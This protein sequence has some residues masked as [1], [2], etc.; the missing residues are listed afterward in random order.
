MH[1]THTHTRHRQ[2]GFTDLIVLHETRGEPDGMI[3]QHLPYGPSFY[4]TLFNVVTRHEIPNVGHMS[5]Q[6]P[7]LIFENFSTKLGKRV[8]D[9]LKYLFP[10]VTNPE[11][12]RIMT[13]DN[14]NDFISFRHHQY[15]KDPV[16]FRSPVVYN[17]NACCLLSK[18]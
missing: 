6:Y 9:G 2:H 13:F 16:C 1:T 8:S 17:P 3:V 10:V 12:T 7:H 5:Q 18:R 14:N 15:H 11:T 4:F